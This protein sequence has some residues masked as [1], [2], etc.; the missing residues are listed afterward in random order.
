MFGN[1]TI[2]GNV[3]VVNNDNFLFRIDKTG[4]NQ[5][6]SSGNT[7]NLFTLATLSNATV[8]NIPLTSYSLVNNALKLPALAGFVD[9]NIDIRLT[10]TISGN[11]Q[12]AREFSIELRRGNDTLVERKAVIKINDTT[13]DARGTNLETYSLGVDDPFT[14]SGIKLIVNNTSGQ[15]LTITGFS[16][17]IKGDK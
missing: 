4:L 17:I 15:T 9:Y 6:L 1:N 10:G 16:I 13:L 11:V 7:L 14:A 3:N 5:V 8:A 12:T 2:S